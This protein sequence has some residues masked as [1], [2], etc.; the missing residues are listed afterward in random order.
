LARIYD[1]LGK[2]DQARKERETM[3]RIQGRSGQTGTATGDP[4][5]VL[6]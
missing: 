5:L 6:Q 3:A 2:H 1:E 4:V